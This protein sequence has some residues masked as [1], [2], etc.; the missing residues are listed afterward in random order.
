MSLLD[1]LYIEIDGSPLYYYL[2]AIVIVL[3]IL[4]LPDDFWRN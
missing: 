1:L 4:S 3:S 2:I